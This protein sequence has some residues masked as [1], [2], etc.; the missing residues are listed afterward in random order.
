MQYVPVRH[1]RN[2]IPVIDT[3]VPGEQHDPSVAKH[4]MK[5]ELRREHG[6]TDLRLETPFVTRAT[7]V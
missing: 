3:G 1:G 4:T 6:G 5:E 2:D 7:T